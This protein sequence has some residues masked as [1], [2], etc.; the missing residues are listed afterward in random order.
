MEKG[1]S[2][3]MVGYYPEVFAKMMELRKTRKEFVGDDMG[4]FYRNQRLITMIR[5][6]EVNMDNISEIMTKER[7]SEDDI[8]MEWYYTNGYT[9]P[10]KV[11]TDLLQKNFNTSR[12][13]KGA[14]CKLNALTMRRILMKILMRRIDKYEHPQ[15]YEGNK[16]LCIVGQSGSGKTLCS[17]H[18]QN[19][20]GANVICSFTTRPP[21]KTEVEGREH[22]FINIVPDPNEL[23]AYAVFGG[24]EYYALKTQVFG[25]CTVYVIDEQGLRNLINEHGDEY[26]I[27]SV[28]L[29]R[30]WN[31]RIRTG[32]KRKRMERDADREELPLSDYDYVIEN[33]GTKKELFNN[34]ERI[35]NEVKEK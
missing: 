28:Y 15:K 7:M 6:G 3:R 13:K 22:H 14:R 10:R 2:A 35:Y 34:I 9:D 20:L 19:K 33:N 18:L 21:R 4:T 17:L 5:D 25:D 23:L 1:F 12:K 26:K 8:P 27:Y 30:D 11:Q 31:K 24:F 29:K 16:I 32:V